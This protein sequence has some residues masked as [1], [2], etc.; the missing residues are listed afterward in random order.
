MCVEHHTSLLGS[1]I[2]VL[3]DRASRKSHYWR[4]LHILLVLQKKKGGKKGTRSISQ[5][6]KFT[7]L[8]DERAQ[9]HGRGN[10]VFCLI[11]KS[12]D[13]SVRAFSD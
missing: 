12:C 6:A 10:C 13:I 8:T 9:E 4:H 5:N 7:L 11:N 1:E 2:F 3:Q